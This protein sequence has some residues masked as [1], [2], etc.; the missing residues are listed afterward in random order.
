[1][2]QLPPRHSDP[3]LRFYHLLAVLELVLASMV[4]VRDGKNLTPK[5]LTA[6]SNVSA[7]LP[8]RSGIAPSVYDVLVGLHEHEYTGG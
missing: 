7:R 4:S 3:L 2:K 6:A 8:E 1:M 5:R